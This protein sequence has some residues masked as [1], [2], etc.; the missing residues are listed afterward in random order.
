MKDPAHHIAKLN[1]EV[2]RHL[3]DEIDPGIPQHQ[4][5]RQVKKQAKEK[6][7]QA[8]LAR[9]VHHLTPDEQNKKMSNRTP[10]FDRISH[11]KPFKPVHHSR[12]KA[13]PI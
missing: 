11:D 1:R 8:K 5:E 6:A 9:P 2:I 4:T 7:K 13:P 3:P 10:I 12:K